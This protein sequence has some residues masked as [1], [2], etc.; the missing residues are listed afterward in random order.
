[1]SEQVSPGGSTTGNGTGGTK[2]DAG[3]EATGHVDAALTLANMP[4]IAAVQFLAEL[5]YPNP[6][7]DTP[8]GPW[9]PVMRDVLDRLAVGRPEVWR[10]N[11]LPQDPIP[12]REAVG[13]SS[14]YGPLPDPW[15]RQAGLEVRRALGRAVYTWLNPQPLPPEPPRI[16]FMGAIADRMA[17]EAYPKANGQP[18]PFAQLVDEICGNDF[19]LR[20][21]F[22]WPPPPWWAGDV[23][24]SDLV[25][26]GARMGLLANRAPE[27]EV[28]TRLAEAS[29]GMFNRGIEQLAGLALPGS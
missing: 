3:N 19:R 1:M 4:A 14:R 22:P 21:P 7:D 11:E 10:A 29:R 23:R 16:R 24:G 5:F 8:P 26:A 12:W 9:G 15:R 13:G 17:E 20:W 25:L 27:G 6:D 2:A 28:R 18:G